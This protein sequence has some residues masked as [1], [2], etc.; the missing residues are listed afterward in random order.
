MKPVYTFEEAFAASKEYFNGNELAAD[1]FVNKYALKDK[2][3]NYHEKT[4]ANM[5]RR[6]A[7]EFAR[8]EKKKYK[9]TKTPPLTEDEI[10]TLLDKFKKVIPQGSPMYGIGNNTQYVSLANCFAIP[11]PE[12]SYGGICRAD[13]E[14]AQISKRRGGCVRS[15]SYVD[16]KN[17]G[18]VEI[19]DVNIGDM[20]LSYNINTGQDEYK[21]ILDHYY[22]EVRKKDQIKITTSHGSSIYTSVKHPISVLKDNKHVYIKAGEVKNDDILIIPESEKFDNINDSDEQNDLEWF[23]GAHAGDGSAGKTKIM[24]RVK[25][26]S[27]ESVD[28]Q[29]DYIDISVEDNNNYYAGSVGLINI[30]N[31][32]LDISKLR[33]NKTPTTNS[34]STST[35]IIPFMCRFSNT[36]REVGQGNRR[37]A[38]MQSISIHHPECVILWDDKVDGKPYDIEINSRE[39]GS[40]TVSSQHFNPDKIDFVT[41][42]YDSTKVTGSNISVRITDEFMEAVKKGKTYQQRWPVDS[43]NPQ[44]TKEV[45]AKKAWDKLIRS[46]HRV[47]DPGILLWDNIL[48]ES[49]SDCY[50]SWGFATV[51]VNPC[52]ELILSAYGSCILMLLN[53]FGFVKNPYTKEAYFDYEDFYNHVKITQRLADDLIDLEEEALKKIIKK[54]RNDPE[55][56]FIKARELHLWQKV[57]ETLTKGRRTGT[58]LTA[59]GDTLASIGV[60]YGTQKGIKTAE[61]IFRTFKFA[62]YQSSVDMAKALEPFEIWNHALE[63]DNPYL[64]RIR[65]EAILLGEKSVSGAELYNNMTKYGRRNIALLTLAPAGTVSLLASLV[66]S[67]GTSSGVEPQYSTQ[68]II[69]R[70][71]I[72]ANDEN[73]RVDYVDPNGDKWQ[74]FE[75]YP[76]AMLEWMRVN[77]ETDPSKSPWHNN[78]AEELD[79]KMR[80]KLQGTIQQEVDHSISSTINLPS[81][82]TVNEVKE[83]YETAWNCGCKGITIYRD[84]CRTGVLIKDLRTL[85]TENTIT[86]NKSPK[87]PKELPCDIH[88]ITV[89]GEQYFVCVGVFGEYKDPYEIFA[90]KNGNIPK[91]MKHG[92]VIKVKRGKYD[93]KLENG[94]TIENI[95]QYETDEEE[96][97]TRIIST[98]LRHGADIQFVVHQL[99]KTQGDL[100]SFAKSIAR[101]LKK[102]IKDGTKIQGMECEIC[103]GELQRKEGCA[104]CISC[105]WSKCN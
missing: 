67:F 71:K 7:K 15:D 48:K 68:K 11:G 32:G 28:K 35:G 10:F 98:A 79:W 43:D 51:G 50:A 38:S 92:S 2:D 1:K 33:P 59:L 104:F 17:K 100:T 86:K 61:R 9:D 26:S 63:K 103:H 64:N 81:D 46:A 80:I 66:D 82:V 102:Y 45:D 8:I 95:I 72:N 22:T 73:V 83:I 52:A 55:D 4:P 96:V 89:K 13:E 12:D 99:E 76:E 87:R 24:Q 77:N 58:G 25:V 21:K 60:E 70:T 97:T 85:S 49:I 47:A 75:V 56:S 27:I 19:Q 36:T 91:N 37:G 29:Y 94:N 30:H 53:L 39:Y 14:I 18:L 16:I 105:G 20:I 40:F 93:L 78:T 74:H 6:M 44:I 42:K 88:H 34:S 54:V 3:N 62:A 57:K 69:R 84:G 101:A 5:H 65:D 31:C 23:I 90:G 41:S